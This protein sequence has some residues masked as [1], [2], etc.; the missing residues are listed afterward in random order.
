MLSSSRACCPEPGA[1]VGGPPAGE[2]PCSRPTSRPTGRRP[3]T[4]VAGE[5]RRRWSTLTRSP[6]THFSSSRPRSR[7]TT[8]RE[9]T[10]TSMSH[11]LP[12]PPTRHLYPAGH[13]V[14]RLSLGGY[15]RSTTHDLKLST[16]CH[17]STCIGTTTCL[18]YRCPCVMVTPV[19]L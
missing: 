4:A 17:V 8:E 7:E 6:L 9:P 18:Q 12:L 11:T 13:L 16:L 14:V 3:Q 1:P 2:W 15:L 5:A 19:L 10:G